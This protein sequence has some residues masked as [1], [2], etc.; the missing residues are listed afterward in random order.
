MLE[1]FND[2]FANPYDKTELRYFGTYNNGKWDNGILQSDSNEW[3]VLNGIPCF[4]SDREGDQFSQEEINSWIKGGRFLRRWTSKDNNIKT[5]NDVYY[6]LC[7]KAADLDLPIME[8]ACGPGLGLLPDIIVKNPGIKCLATDA[9]SSLIFN[10]KKFFKDNNITSNVSFAT[11]DATNM[12]ICSNSVDVITSYIG[13]SSIR[14][15]AGVDGMMGIKEAYRVLKH[16]GYIF[17]IENAWTDRNALHEV[18]KLWG[19]EYYFND[20]E[21]N[22]HEK[23]EKTNFTILDEKPQ[24]YRL[25]TP[26]DNYLGEA[27]SRFGIEIGLQYTAYILRKM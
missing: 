7:Q 10:W 12:P 3:Q 11:F 21:M 16:G 17:A 22:W 20:N 9:C 14:R 6:S 8:V 4:S 13:F 18:F 5:N 24:Q 25:L 19:K 26:Q 2:I 23:F 1:C 27:A 15:S